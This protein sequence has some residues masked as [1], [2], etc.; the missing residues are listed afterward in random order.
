MPSILAVLV[1]A[2]AVPASPAVHAAGSPRS[3]V[4]SSAPV[5]RGAFH[6]AMRKPREDHVTWTRLY[7]VSAVASLPDAQPTAER[8][9]RNQSD[10][11]DAIKPYSGDA[12]GERLTGLLRPHILIAA[13]LVK[14]AKAGDTAAVQTQSARWYANAD[15]IADFLS[16]PNPRNWPAATLRSETH[17]HLDLTLQE[18]QA[19][20]RQDWAADIAVYDA[21]HEHILGMADVLASGIV[22][23]FPKRFK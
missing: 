4:A 17:H 10:L 1:L 7:I 22:K 23:Q 15:E 9:L 13:E 16:G 8:L 21:V 19:R 11:G 12:A 5:D 14:A 20:L 6:D 3:A 2:L 18:A